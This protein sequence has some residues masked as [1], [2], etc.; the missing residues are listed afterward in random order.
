MLVRKVRSAS[1]EAFFRLFERFSR[2]EKGRSIL[3]RISRGFCQE[4]PRLGDEDLGD[5]PYADLG[6]ADP[7]GGVRARQ[8]IIF[9]TGRFRSGTTFLWNIFRSI[10]G[11][12]AYY[13]PFNERRWFDPAARGARVDATHKN[14]AE[15]WKEYEGLEDI[16]NYYRLEWTDTNLY[17][18]ARFP[19]VGMRKYIERMVEHAAGRPVL[20]FNRVDF[21]LPWLKSQFPGAKI[22]HL[23]RHPRDQWC[24]ALMGR[25]CPRDDMTFSS[26]EPYDGF[27]LT[28]WV[29]DLKYPFPFLDET[30]IAHPYQAFYLIWRLS[31]AFG[32]RY[33]DASIRFEELVEDP[34]AIAGR[35]LDALGI[36]DHDPRK[37]R[38]IHAKPDLGKWRAYADDDWFRKHESRC[39]TVL[40]EHFGLASPPPAAKP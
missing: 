29:R 23:Y 28:S 27:Y 21:R 37:I 40:K 2:H 24:S 30:E 14:V 25:A 15:Y 22:V 38:E 33:A 18:D 31:H 39:E 16:G 36:R 1:R 19:D 5:P 11:M 6:T 20:Q 13:E 7:R 12:T 8:D 26:F 17:M 4:E 34:V 32:R 3:A 9:I 35:L 10:P